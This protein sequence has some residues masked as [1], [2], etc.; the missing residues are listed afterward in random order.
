MK[1]FSAQ[2]I[3]NEKIGEN[4]FELI[5]KSEI[6]NCSPQPGQ[7]TTIRVSTDTTPLLR[8]PFAYSY[9]DK[10]IEQCSIIYQKRGKTTEIL[11]GKQAGEI[12]DCIGPIGNHFTL[13]AADTTAILVAGGIGVGPIQYF[14]SQLKRLKI[15]YIFI[16]GARNSNSIPRNGI[17]E[18]ID[19]IICTDDGSS[20]FK[21]TTAD[22][23]HK[24][25]STI[26]KKTVFYCCGPHP[27]LKACYEFS[28]KINCPCWV[29]VEQ[30]MACGVG[31]CMGCVVKVRSK[32]K[33]ARACK[34]GPIFNGKELN[35]NKEE[36]F[37]SLLPETYI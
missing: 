13:P 17:F 28:K 30:V 26:P 4:F 34:D 8:R 33:Y 24:C 22:Y 5:L 11:S 6:K 20:G 21:G 12:I 27:M 3:K 29:S 16:F 25:S 15:P 37:D 18:A 36:E 9:Y 1:Q 2:I 7:F 14:A 32:Q 23:L 35:W 31:A 19:P 10:Q